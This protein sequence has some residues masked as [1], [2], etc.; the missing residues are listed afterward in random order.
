V[1]RQIGIVSSLLGRHQH[2]QSCLEE[3]CLM[4]KRLAG[5]DEQRETRLSYLNCIS[6]RLEKAG[7]PGVPQTEIEAHLQDWLDLAEQCA[8]GGQMRL[9]LMAW[10]NHAIMLQIDG[11]NRAAVDALRALV[12]R[13]R[14]FGMR[15]NE[16]LA[17]AEM[18]RSH[19][20]LNEPERARQHYRE[21]L[22]VLREAGAQADLLQALE[23]LARTEEALGEVAAALAALKELRTIEQR[24]K[25]EAARQALVQRELRIELARMS[26]QWA[27][28]ALQDPL[29][30]LANRRGLE[31]WLDEH[32]PR[33]ERGEDLALLLLDLDHFKLVNDRFGHDTGDRV[34][35]EVAGLLQS[36]ARGS[37][38]A[39]RYGGEEFLLAMAGTDPDAAHAAAHRLRAAVASQDWPSLADGLGV[40][41]S[42][43]VADASEV[44]NPAGLLTMADRRLYAAKYG[45]RDRVVTQG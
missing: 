36:Q 24:R 14:E 30:G 10:G 8:A 4:T 42:I 13:Y 5:A 15:P 37:D 18:A 11:R 29:T 25:D 7:D 35:C 27:R 6:R 2:A 21:A 3:A 45:G 22:Q 20:T 9:A 32:W 38:L 41:V 26:N 23:G 33:A 44:L 28:Q 40:T 43:G 31:R 17:L 12:P 1:L 19:E 34:L 16:G 39:V